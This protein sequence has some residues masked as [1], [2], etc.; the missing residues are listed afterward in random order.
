MLVRDWMSP[1]SITLPSEM[2]ILEALRIMNSKGIPRIMVLHA[3]KVSGIVSSAELYEQLSEGSSTLLCRK[4][5]AD[6]LPASVAALAPDDPLDRAAQFLFETARFALP[7]LEH[8]SAVGVISAFDVCRAFRKVFSVRSE[9]A[10]SLVMMNASRKNDLL[11]EIRHRT[12]GSAIQS[13]LA[14]P[15]SRQEWQVMVRLEPAESKLE[16]CA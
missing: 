5:L 2:Q 12:N 8:G 15:S 6:L 4:S 16:S 1:A 7:V 14:Y 3:G 9:D 10:A 11:E 13:L